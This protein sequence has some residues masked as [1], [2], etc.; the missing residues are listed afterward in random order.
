MIQRNID[1]LMLQETK[2]IHHKDQ[3][4]IS[5]I[6]LSD[7]SRYIHLTATP[8]ANGRGASG[9]LAFLISPAN[10][11]YVSITKQL[12]SRIL[13]LRIDQHIAGKP[14]T[15]HIYNVYAPTADAQH[16]PD[17]IQL[18]NILHDSLTSIPRQDM[19]LLGGDFN[20]PLSTQ[21]K[22]VLYQPSQTRTNSNSAHLND[23]L[24]AHDLLPI[25]CR[26]PK[27]NYKLNTFFGPNNRR[28][29]LDYIIVPG[30][31]SS[32][33]SDFDTIRAPFSTDHK[34]L[35]ARGK[36]KFQ[37]QKRKPAIPRKNWTA[38]TKDTALA[39]TVEQRFQ[40]AY[41]PDPSLDLNSTYTNFVTAAHKATATVPT[42]SRRQQ[43]HP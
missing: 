21:M 36:F 40:A 25:N 10:A 6:R 26:L 8:G 20:A 12:S 38:L 15:L 23:F 3:P 7:G 39:A 43:K 17:T 13:Y 34:L 2:H 41:T 33:F 35:I 16:Q 19:L 27:P 1:V 37:Q 24:N 31:W 18:Y 4:P 14:Q 22:S 9:G 42:I 5:D 32:T 28:Q 30:K 11:N 29:R